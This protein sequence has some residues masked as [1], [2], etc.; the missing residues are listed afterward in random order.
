MQTKFKFMACCHEDVLLL[1]FDVPTECI[2][3]GGDYSEGDGT[4]T[5]IRLSVSRDT[6]M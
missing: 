4:Q 2:T 3:E 1:V 5:S 6:C